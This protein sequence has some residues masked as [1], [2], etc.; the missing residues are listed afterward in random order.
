MGP[1]PVNV[2]GPS[3]DRFNTT[4]QLKSMNEALTRMLDEVQQKMEKMQEDMRQ[5][6]ECLMSQQQVSRC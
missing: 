2:F 5:M 3:S 6:K 1:T 4:S